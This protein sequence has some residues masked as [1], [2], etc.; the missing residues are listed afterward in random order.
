MTQY[1]NNAWTESSGNVFQSHDPATG[2][3]IWEGKSA[4]KFDVHDA[5]L[6]AKNA[7]PGWSNLSIETRIAYFE[8]FKHALTEDKNL[9][10]E[11]ISQETGKPLWDSTGEV[12]AMLNKIALSIDAYK[13]RCAESTRTLPTG[14]SITR[15]KPHGVVA[16][17]GPF[18]FPAH[19][20]NGH[21]LPALL[22]GNTVVFKPS[23]LTPL[24]G[25]VMVD[26]WEKCFLPKGVINLV[27]GGRETGQFLAEH[28]DFNGLF[29][30]GSWKTGK[31]LSEQFAGHPEKILAL[32]MGGN[33]P[34]IVSGVKDLKAAAY[35]ALQSAYLSAG[36]RCTCARRLIVIENSS[37]EAFIEQLIQLIQKITVGVYNQTPEPF[38]GPVISPQS[39][40]SLLAAQKDLKKLGGRSLVEMRHLQSE[41]GLLSP[42]LMDVTDISSRPDEEHFGPFLQLIRVPNLEA[43]LKEANNTQYG[44]SAGILT[45]S[46]EEYELFY[47][48]IRAGVVNWNTPMTGASSAA[49]FGGV[50]RSGNHRPS[51][52]YAA[53]YCCYPVASME[54]VK[55]ELPGVISPGLSIT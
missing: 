36:Q 35:V 25:E 54:T 14:T 5:V 50:G 11:T 21:I 46:R 45:D 33:N 39:A 29:F 38:M 4:G 44:L 51:A 24:V 41:T 31:I 34:L 7:L 40:H 52:F 1:I 2:E 48:E 13:Q 6:A 27:Q 32:E 42:G 18:N 16:V 28:P 10:A 20:P 23:E 55:L 17:F 30:T 26:I 19:L 9:L 12:A 37:H 3:K 15:H 22:A 47:R 8:A 49:P 53:D 43:A